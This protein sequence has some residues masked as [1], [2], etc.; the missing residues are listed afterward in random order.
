MLKLFLTSVI[1]SASLLAG[2]I[3][4]AVAA[5]LSDAVESLKTEFAKTNPAI[6]VIPF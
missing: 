2:E 5:N 1:L 3:S 6:K 4:V